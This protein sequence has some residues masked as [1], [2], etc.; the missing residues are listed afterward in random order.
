[1]KHAVPGGRRRTDAAR[2]ISSA[3]TAVIMVVAA[4]G[5][6]TSAARPGAASVTTTAPTTVAIPPAGP[7][8]PAAT[9]GTPTSQTVSFVPTKLTLPSGDTAPVD[10]AGVSGDGVLQV[11][12]DASRVGWWT[13]GALAGE[14][15][16]SIVIAGHVDSRVY[17]IG[18]MSELLSAEVG[19]RLLLDDGTNTRMYE[20]SA[21]KQAPKAQLA[22]AT[23]AFRQDVDNRLVLITCVGAYDHQAHAY[24]D[25]LVV[26]ANEIG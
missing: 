12:D 16:G 22:A 5:C 19:D 18:I 1:M 11:P 25:N 26:I 15:F 7:P 14:P 6:G 10:P 3:L 8:T 13:G 17:G 24:P 23:D 2:R 4:G 21:I 9:A 20:V